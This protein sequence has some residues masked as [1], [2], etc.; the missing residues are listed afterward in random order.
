MELNEK[1]RQQ[2]STALYGN[3]SQAASMEDYIMH[4]PQ[5]PLISAY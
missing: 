3:N 4:E 2:L 5:R 1:E